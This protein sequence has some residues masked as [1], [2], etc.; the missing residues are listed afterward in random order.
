MIVMPVAIVDIETMIAI[1]PMVAIIMRI[2][3][4][5]SMEIGGI[6]RDSTA[7]SGVAD[8]F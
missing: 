5:M 7:T 8:L 1:N 6:G 4:G 3:L 2:D